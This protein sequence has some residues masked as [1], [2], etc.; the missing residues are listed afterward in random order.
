MKRE[1]LLY[2]GAAA[3][4]L[5]LASMYFGPRAP[6]AIRTAVTLGGLGLFLVAIVAIFSYRIWGLVQRLR[7]VTRR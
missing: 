6:E 1:H 3:F 7:N 2:G 4:V 5:G